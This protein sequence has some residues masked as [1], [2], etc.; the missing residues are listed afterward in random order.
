M[1]KSN[2]SSLK[3]CWKLSNGSRLPTPMALSTRLSSS[4]DMLK[5]W[6]SRKTK[7]FVVNLIYHNWA[8][9]LCSEFHAVLGTLTYSQVK[10]RKLPMAESLYLL[11]FLASSLLTTIFRIEIGLPIAF[12]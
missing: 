6:V 12:W 2:Y 8:F 7:P 5:E 10:N 1:Q 3:K 4:E 9:Y 11:P